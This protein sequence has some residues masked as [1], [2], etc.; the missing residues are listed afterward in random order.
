[1]A[2]SSWMYGYLFDNNIILDY[3][4]RQQKENNMNVKNAGCAGMNPS[5]F[6]PDEKDQEAVSYAKSLCR[7]CEG[8]LEC[9]K[10][11]LQNHE[12]EGIWGG[13]TRLERRLIV[14]HQIPAEDYIRINCGTESGYQRHV[15]THTKVCDDCRSAHTRKMV[16][17]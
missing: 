7:K 9:L 14:R 6:Y 2:Q 5:I 8:R 10:L 1:M 4:G 16:G 11:A 17:I 15:S 13:T 12:D 3:S